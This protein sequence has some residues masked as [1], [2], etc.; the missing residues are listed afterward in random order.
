MFSFLLDCPLFIWHGQQLIAGEHAC[1]V[2]KD[3]SLSIAYSIL[4]VYGVPFISVGLIY[5]KV[6]LFLHRQVIPNS[7]HLRRT[8]RSQQRDIRV[9]R[10]IV[11]IVGLLGSFGM[12]VSIMLLILAFTGELMPYFY[13]IL[14]L[15]VCI[16]ILTLS[17]ALVYVTS[18]LKNKIKFCCRQTP[19]V[20]VAR[21]VT[22]PKQLPT[23][24]IA[25]LSINQSSRRQ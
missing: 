11:C 21:T 7:I 5:F 2:S 17:I 22:A 6:T 4:S 25:Q 19:V 23:E 15:S 24:R 3:D 10:H 13:R 8:T 20:P 14:V 16:C 18:Q 12:P 9:L 1:L